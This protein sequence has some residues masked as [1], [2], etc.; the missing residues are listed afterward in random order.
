MATLGLANIAFP[1]TIKAE[2]PQAMNESWSLI[3]RKSKTQTR[4]QFRCLIWRIAKRQ[5]HKKR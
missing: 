3:N 4:T 1:Q 5:P 2:W